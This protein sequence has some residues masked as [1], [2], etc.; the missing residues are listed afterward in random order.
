MVTI[1]EL[2]L[3][4]EG[5]GSDL[6]AVIKPYLPAL[7]REGPDVYDGF[8]KSLLNKDFVAI[9]AL[10]YDKMT[11]EERS[12]LLD[13]VY[14]DGL[15]AAR[16]QFSRHQLTNDILFKVTLAILARLVVAAI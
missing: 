15:A 7:A 10:M 6:I 12:A 16:A 2:S 11:L 1:D 8:I 4:A 13:E 3:A 14:A 9:D 5:I